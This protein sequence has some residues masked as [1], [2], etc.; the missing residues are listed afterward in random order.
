MKTITIQYKAIVGAQ[1]ITEAVE[2][3]YSDFEDQDFDYIMDKAPLSDLCEKMKI[4]I[5]NQTEIN[6]WLAMQRRNNDPSSEALT[7]AQ[8]NPQMEAGR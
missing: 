3:D 5:T 8:R 6:D 7:P 4:R 2:V 1:E